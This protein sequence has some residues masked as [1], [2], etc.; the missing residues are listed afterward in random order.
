MTSVRHLRGINFVGKRL[1]KVGLIIFNSFV[2]TSI[3][4]IFIY[5]TQNIRLQI[6]LVLTEVQI[7]R[8]CERQIWIQIIIQL[9]YW[10]LSFLYN[11]K[12]REGV[13]RHLFLYLLKTF[14]SGQMKKRFIWRWVILTITMFFCSRWMSLSFI[15]ICTIGVVWSHIQV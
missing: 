3:L 8:S 12:R 14:W 1:S 9:N 7:Q 13:K 11:I 5:F 2:Q 4:F 6:S 10:A 15:F